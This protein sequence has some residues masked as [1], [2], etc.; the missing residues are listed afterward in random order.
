LKNKI[1]DIE[2]F[3][4]YLI[5]NFAKL[6]LFFEILAKLGRSRTAQHSD[7]HGYPKF[8]SWEWQTG[9]KKLKSK[10]KQIRSFYPKW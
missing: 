3:T 6:A 1:V 7:L 4:K 9:F 2:L 5:T 8:G 10:A